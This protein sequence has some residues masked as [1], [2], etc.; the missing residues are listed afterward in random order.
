MKLRKETRSK[1][2]E[3]LENEAQ[4]IKSA[5]VT[6]DNLSEMITFI[7]ADDESVNIKACI[8]MK[9]IFY[10]KKSS[11]HNCWV[12]VVCIEDIITA[13]KKLKESGLIVDSFF[14]RIMQSFP[15][16]DGGYVDL[17]QSNYLSFYS[18]A[19]HRLWFCRGEIPDVCFE[20]GISAVFKK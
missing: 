14:N 15:K 13:L 3:R 19:I 4:V 2:F 7:V 12:K 20:G 1:S 5:E 16:P 10:W 11:D 8:G 17:T 9:N 6:V 18:N